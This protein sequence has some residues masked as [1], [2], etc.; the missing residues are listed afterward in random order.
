MKAKAVKLA[1]EYVYLG[2][3]EPSKLVCRCNE[4]LMSQCW[5]RC[6]TLGGLQSARHCL[7]YIRRLFLSTVL[8]Q[9]FSVNPWEWKE[10]LV[11]C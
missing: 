3:T 2:T 9:G 10:K 1:A 7:V 4:K 11:H 5:P 8:E 6:W